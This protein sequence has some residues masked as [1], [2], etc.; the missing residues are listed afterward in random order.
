MLYVDITQA[1]QRSILHNDI[2]LLSSQSKGESLW[3]SG[4]GTYLLNRRYMLIVQRSPSARVNPGMF[5]LFTGRADNLAELQC[6]R[7]LVRELFEELILYSTTRLLKPVCYEFQEIID[8]AYTK[9]SSDIQLDDID[10]ESLPLESISLVPRDIVVV[11]SNKIWNDNLTY[12]ISQSRD[13]NFLFL[14]AGEVDINSLVA[15]DGEYHLENG[16]VIIHNR[17]IFI[18]DIYTSIAKNISMGVREQ[19]MVH[20]PRNLMTEHMNYLVELISKTYS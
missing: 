16:E 4:G 3:V 10:V 7:L 17:N 13:V 6:P 9:L 1:L 12:Y 14:L 11:N 5:S 15:K 8:R 18:Y 19:E 2:E 20:I